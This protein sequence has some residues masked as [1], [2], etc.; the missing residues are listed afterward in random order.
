[1]TTTTY[2]LVGGPADGQQLEVNGAQTLLLRTRVTDWG[3]G[4]GWGE[5]VYKRREGQ[6]RFYDYTETRPRP[7]YL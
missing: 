6:G 1:V 3:P 5:A 2:E 4:Y 7:E